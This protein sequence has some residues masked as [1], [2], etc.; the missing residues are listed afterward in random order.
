MNVV[1]T[2]TD[3][4]WHR[5]KLNDEIDDTYRIK[6]N[7]QIEAALKDKMKLGLKTERDKKCTKEFDRDKMNKRL[8]ILYEHNLTDP[9]K[10]MN[11]KAKK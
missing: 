5:T 1:A 2:H 9:D 10:Q 6:I 11:E 4:V 3:R 7:T 8:R